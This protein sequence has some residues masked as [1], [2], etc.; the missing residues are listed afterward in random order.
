M[1]LTIQ[2]HFLPP[3]SPNLNPIERFWKWMKQKIMYN[4]YY[5]KYDDFKNTIFG[6]LETLSNLKPE[7]ELYK[8]FSSRIREHFRAIGSPITD[9]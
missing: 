6:F 3:Y 2:A 4:T 5:R 1:L 7:T 8:I 9:S